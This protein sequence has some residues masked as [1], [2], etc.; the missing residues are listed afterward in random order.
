MAKGASTGTYAGVAASAS[1]ESIASSALSTPTATPSKRAASP[2]KRGAAAKVAKTAAASGTGK[3][4]EPSNGKQ[5]VVVCVRMRPLAPASAPPATAPSTPSKNN[6]DKASAALS[7]AAVNGAECWSLDKDTQSITATEHHPALAKRGSSSAP[8]PGANDTSQPGEDDANG[9]YKFSFDSLTLP[10]ETGDEVYEQHIAPIIRAAA[11][12]YNATVFA[13]GQTGS[14]KTHTMSGSKAEKGIIPRAVEEIFEEINKDDSREYLLRVSYLEIYNESLKD[15]LAAL[16]ST[17]GAATSKSNASSES[18]RPASPTKGGFSHSS[19]SSTALGK[20]GAIRIIEDKGR[21]VLTG[22]REEIVT[23]PATVLKLIEDGQSM[24]H[25]GATDWNE[26][27]SRSHCVFQITIES[28]PKACGGMLA[29]A[30]GTGETR[31]SQLNLIDLAGSERA[32]SQKARRKEGAFINKSLLTLGTVIAKLTEA[33]GEDGSVNPNSNSSNSNSNSSTADQTH[34][35]Y[36]DSKLTRILQTSLGGN[37]RVAVICTLSPDPKHAIET[38]STLKF[39]RRCKMVVTSAK[40]GSIM[41]DKALLQK[42]K[43]EL[44][45]LKAQLEAGGGAVAA[46][47]ASGSAVSMSIDEEAEMSTIRE[48]ATQKEQGQKEVDEML[49][50]KEKLRGQIDHLT[51]LILTSKKVAEDSASDAAAG[52]Q[53]INKGDPGVLNNSPGKSARRGQRMSELPVRSSNLPSLESVHRQRVP[54]LGTTPEEDVFRTERELA[55]AK[56]QLRQL[57]DKQCTNALEL[58]Q[59][60]ARIRTLEADIKAHENE[61]DEAERAFHL[62]KDERDAAKQELLDGAQELSAMQEALEQEREATRRLQAIADGKVAKTEVED[63]AAKLRLE[64]G[65]LRR[66]AQEAAEKKDLDTQ[67]LQLDLDRERMEKEKR[68]SE[69]QALSAARERSADT[70]LEQQRAQIEQLERELAEFKRKERDSAR[71]LPVPTL[72]Q[73]R[74]ST[75]NPNKVRDSNFWSKTPLP[76]VGGSLPGTPQAGGLRRALFSPPTEDKLDMFSPAGNAS[77]LQRAG[78]LREYRRYEP[79]SESSP[80]PTRPSGLS[81]AFAPSSAV[82]EAAVKAEREEIRR[83]NAVISSQRQLMAD[84]ERSVADWK[85]KLRLQQ[86]LI[87]RLVAESSHE[88]FSIPQMPKSP[89]PEKPR[90]GLAEQVLQLVRLVRDAARPSEARAVAHAPG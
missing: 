32:A 25:V 90:S 37:A 21:I 28:T 84:L 46:L 41:D 7:A 9:T 82:I 35:P 52:D 62:L 44:E 53:A 68:D 43:T 59:H 76:P 89:I 69:A 20:D 85:N 65:Q 31:L 74:G 81:A 10:T 54:V 34:I 14:G 17:S 56:R 15:L 49:K 75:A 47:P 18:T 80:I 33:V 2:I 66:E 4:A 67:R 83:L 5:N 8:L 79:S 1:A 55:A 38:L 50:E 71:P 58:S 12:G 11:E 42:Y 51:R 22:L 24:R 73:V 27:S 77:A 3:T 70:R 60:E 26:R 63:E 19:G 29:T 48:L 13:Y 57:E 87:N 6:K 45:A 36:R 86:D 16:P 78:S 61:L 64:I 39:G 88:G 40:K 23:D 30:S 72:G